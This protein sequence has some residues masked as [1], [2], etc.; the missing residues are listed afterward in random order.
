M[1]TNIVC[2]VCC[3]NLWLCCQIS[4]RPF[5]VSMANAGPNTNGS[6]FFITTVPTP[7]L[8]KHHCL[9]LYRYYFL[10]LRAY[11]SLN[12]FVTPRQ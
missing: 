4:D 10:N 11:T 8:G 2:L 5:T 6:Q 12:A 1:A 9:V 7:W 3:A